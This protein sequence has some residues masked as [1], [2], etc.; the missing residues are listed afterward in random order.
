MTIAHRKPAEK[1]AKTGKASQKRSGPPGSSR[2]SPGNARARP[3][4]HPCE[5]KSHSKH[6]LWLTKTTPGTPSTAPNDPPNRAKSLQN[7]AKTQ[8]RTHRKATPQHP[9]H[10]LT[11]PR[12][13]PIPSSDHQYRALS[14]Q[15]R[16]RTAQEPR[17][18]RART[19]ENAKK[20][21]RH[22]SPPHQQ[23]GPPK[24]P[25]IVQVKSNPAPARSDAVRRSP[26]KLHSGGSY[27]TKS[28][29]KPPSKCPYVLRR[30]MLQGTA[31]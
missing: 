7:P 17:K 12:C 6:T 4:T 1:A 15:N 30:P 20:H 24:P 14:R 28:Y 23:K 9:N 22:R 25:Q 27:L 10:L 19:R 5:R 16:A 21:G 26:K 2:F 29:P 13:I 11:P 18:N 3:Q 8:P 31:S